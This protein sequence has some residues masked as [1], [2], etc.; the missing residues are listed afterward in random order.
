LDPAHSDLLIG[1]KGPV[2]GPWKLVVESR[3]FVTPG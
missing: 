1:T 2:D 3:E